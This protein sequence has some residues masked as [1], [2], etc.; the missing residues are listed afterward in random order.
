MI[1]RSVELLVLS[2]WT[3]SKTHRETNFQVPMWQRRLSLGQAETE[4]A[5]EEG[6]FVGVFFRKK[7]G[8]TLHFSM[9]RRVRSTHVFLKDDQNGE[10]LD[11]HVGNRGSRRG[12]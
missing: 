7:K 12:L 2:A 5:R 6:V 9:A 10:D 1:H 3:F 8:V 4:G 11:H